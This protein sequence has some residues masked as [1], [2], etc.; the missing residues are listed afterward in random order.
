MYPILLNRNKICR[1]GIV[2]ISS[3]HLAKNKL[4]KRGVTCHKCL[5]NWSFKK[6]TIMNLCRN[7]DHALICICITDTKTGF[8]TT[9][10]RESCRLFEDAT[11][12]AP[13]NVSSRWFQWSVAYYKLMQIVMKKAHLTLN[14]KRRTC[15]PSS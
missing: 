12:I 13:T 4:I 7:S 10:E 3:V 5:W 14:G 6:P 11:F 9:W 15:T 8:I 1:K 2:W